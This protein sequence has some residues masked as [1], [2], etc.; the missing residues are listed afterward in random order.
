M[1][2]QKPNRSLQGRVNH[3]QGQLFEGRIEAALQGIS[4][5]ALLELCKI[6]GDSIAW[7]V[8]EEERREL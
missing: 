2:S 7:A 3:A 4:V 1:S 5:S 6:T 8:G